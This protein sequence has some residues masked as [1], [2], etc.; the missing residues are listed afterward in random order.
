[1]TTEVLQADIDKAIRE[2]LPKLVGDVIQRELQTL[3]V[4]RDEITGLRSVSFAQS[5]RIGELSKQI[6]D[7][8]ALRD[9]EISL[10]ARTEQLD[11]KE[12]D[13]KVAELTYRLA[14]RDKS[15]GAIYE[16]VRTIFRAPVIHE[17]LKGLLPAGVSQPNTNYGTPTAMSASVDITKTTEL[18]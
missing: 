3:A 12:R 6:V 2:Q 14:E 8:E 4:L 10:A 17:T 1:M 18:K 16:L 7:Q 13:M 5:N 15:T 11:H 9:R